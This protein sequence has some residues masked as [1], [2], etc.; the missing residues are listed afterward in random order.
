MQYKTT[1]VFLFV[2]LASL[3]NF[4]LGGLLYVVFVFLFFFFSLVVFLV[5]A[6]L[7]RSASLFGCRRGALSALA[8]RCG[9]A[10]VLLRPL[11]SSVLRAACGSSCPPLVPRSRCS[12]RVA[13][14]SCFF[15]P[16]RVCGLVRLGGSSCRCPSSLRFGSLGVGVGFSAC[17]LSNH[18]HYI[19]VAAS[20]NNYILCRLFYS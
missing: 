17:S 20:R 9:R 1:L 6:R 10:F 19:V 7:F 5:A 16:C 4:F 14:R 3:A 11:P 18:T 15:A 13:V 2:V 12:V 8:R